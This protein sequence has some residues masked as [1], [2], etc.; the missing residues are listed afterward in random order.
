MVCPNSVL[1][2]ILVMGC[3]SVPSSF[4]DKICHVLDNNMGGLCQ[5]PE[6]R[7]LALM[8]T[9]NPKRKCLKCSANS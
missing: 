8:A 2:S 6:G 1:L 4:G 7:A 3:V 9:S 5:T